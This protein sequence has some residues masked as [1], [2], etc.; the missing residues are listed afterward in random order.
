MYSRKQW[1]AFAFIVSM[2]TVGVLWVFFR[3]DLTVTIGGLWIVLAIMLRRPKA[4]PVFVSN[5]AL[6]LYWCSSFFPQAMLIVFAVLYPLI[7]I[8]TVAWQ[9][10]K[11]H[12]EREGRIALPPDEEEAV[13]DGNVNQEDVSAV[14]GDQEH[15]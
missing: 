11:R 3:Q 4:A 12:E 13:Q 9:R 8:S 7:Y 2:H 15:R 6:C 1:E 10:L 14:W 5:R